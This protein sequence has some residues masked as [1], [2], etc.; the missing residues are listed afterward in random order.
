MGL[1][2]IPAPCRCAGPCAV[3][4][5]LPGKSDGLAREVRWVVRV[6]GADEKTVREALERLFA[7]VLTVGES[8]EEMTVRAA[9]EYGEFG[10]A[11]A[12]RLY[13]MQACFRIVSGTE[14][15]G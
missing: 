5:T 11:R 9:D 14:E 12:Q 2:L 15:K 10:F 8:G 13:Y 6:Y 3:Y 7:A 4:R 1:P